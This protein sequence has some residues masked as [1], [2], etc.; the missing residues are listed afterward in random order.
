LRERGAGGKT[1]VLHW[2]FT[3]LWMRAKSDSK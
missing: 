3:W 1:T 2:S